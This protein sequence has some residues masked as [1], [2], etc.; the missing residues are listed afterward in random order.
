MILVAYTAGVGGQQIP[1]GT[2]DPAP[3]PDNTNI[4]NWVY[5]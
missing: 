5:L 4:V 1:I 2:G 3:Q